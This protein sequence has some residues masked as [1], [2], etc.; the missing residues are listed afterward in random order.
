MTAPA[1]GSEVGDADVA[2]FYRDGAAVLRGVLSPEWIERMRG[3][4]DRVLASPAPTSMEHVSTAAA[5]RFFDGFF[6]WRCDRD[7]DALVRDSPL[8]S[9]AARVMASETVTLFYDQLF[10]KEPGTSAAT[11]W[12][13]DLPYWPLRGAQI[14]SIW[15]PF[16]RI[17]RE[18]GAVEY[19]A[20]SHLWGRSFAPASFGKISD[21]DARAYRERMKQT[22]LEPVPD[23]ESHRDRYRIL[24]WDVEPGDVI[25]H[26][27]LVLHGAGGNAS[28]ILRRRAIAVRYVGEEAEWHDHPGSFLHAPELAS[29][30]RIELEDGDRLHGPLFPRVWPD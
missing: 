22:G 25:L 10:V 5:G 20:G 26:H 15:V 23:I 11:P 2:S 29:L 17:G 13:H 1:H 27:P 6:L 16:D 4:I 18:N 30:G 14:L 21:A 7:F 24:S 28:S 8:P 19:L 12:H 3:A 9:L